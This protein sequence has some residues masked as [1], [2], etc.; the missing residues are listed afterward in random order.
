MTY[1][2]VEMSYEALNG[3]SFTSL[4]MRLETT[5]IVSHPHNCGYL[6]DCSGG[7]DG[8]GHNG[9]NDDGNDWEELIEDILE[10]VFNR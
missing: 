7:D 10:A 1:D 3:E 5:R 8:G 9:G 6:A 4:P 2:Q